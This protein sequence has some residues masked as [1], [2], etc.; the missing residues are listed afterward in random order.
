MTVASQSR[1]EGTPQQTVCWK[2]SSSDNRTIHQASFRGGP[3]KKGNAILRYCSSFLTTSP[4]FM[5]LGV[6]FVPFNRPYLFL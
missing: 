1:A 3:Q 6:E 5:K 2:S 4:D